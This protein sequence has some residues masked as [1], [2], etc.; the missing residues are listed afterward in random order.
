YVGRASVYNVSMAQNFVYKVLTYEKNPPTDYIKRLMLPTAIL[1]SSYDERPMQD[2]IARMAP[3]D[4]RVSKMYER[5]GTLS[6]QGM[7]D[8]MNVG[9][10]FGHWE[11]HGNENGIYMGGPYLTSSDADGLVNGDRVGIANCIGCM[12]GG[13]DLTPGGDCFAEHLVNR[14][15]GGL[16]AAIM[17]SRYGWGAYVGGY[18]PG[19]SERIDT[20]FYANIF[21]AG[22]FHLGPVHAVAKDAWVYYADSGYQYDMTR[23][24]IYE[25]N[26]FGDPEMPLWTDEP[27]VLTV[28]YPAVIPMGNQNVNVIVTSNGSPVNNALVCLQKGTEVYVSDY[29]DAS[30]LVTL[31]VAPTSPGQMYITA[32]AQNHYPFEDSLMV[33]ATTYAYVTY[34]KCSISDPIP[35]GNNNG[36]LNPGESVEI[37]LWVKNWGQSQGDDITGMLSSTDTYV[38]LSDTIKNFGNIPANDSAYTGADGYN[39]DISPTCPNYHSMLFTLTCNDDV[40][41]TWVSQ[42]N[43]MVY[44]PILT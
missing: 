37:P 41:S 19:P 27:I 6:R 4:W 22:M 39:L 25:L 17:N 32:T 7:I 44:A 31:S 34:L 15:G 1:W 26:L 21:Q 10:N 33:V 30:G 40:D 38:V 35:G 24:C 13:W 3:G 12:C 2:S 18:V 23:W 9:Y 8:T 20:T 11:G 5:N 28:N 43:L 16:L 29:T 14:V 42:F 36:Q